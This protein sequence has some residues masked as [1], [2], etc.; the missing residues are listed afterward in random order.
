MVC[1]FFIVLDYQGSVLTRDHHRT[2]SSLHSPAHWLL[3]TKL[4]RTEMPMC[5]ER[6]PCQ[7]V[8]TNAVCT[9]NKIKWVSSDLANIS[10]A[11]PGS[12]N[13]DSSIMIWEKTPQFARSQ[14]S[15]RQMQ[16]VY[17]WQGQ[18]DVPDHKGQNSEM[19]TVE[20]MFG[21]CLLVAWRAT[22][23]PLKMELD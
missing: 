2:S 17:T 13:A 5:T 15:N 9:W 8:K 10:G 6:Y 3:L 21:K 1:A 12:D 11:V 14:I 4:C 22:S 23:I 7:A 16:C 19:G 18:D 20:Q